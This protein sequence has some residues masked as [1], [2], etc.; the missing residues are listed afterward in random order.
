[1]LETRLKPIEI[2]KKNYTKLYNIQA[3]GVSG[4]INTGRPQICIFRDH[5]I[6]EL[7]FLTMSH[8]N[9]VGTGGYPFFKMSLAGANRNFIFESPTTIDVT[10]KTIDSINLSPGWGGSSG[11]TSKF[12]FPYVFK[13]KDSLLVEFYNSGFGVAPTIDLTLHGICR[14]DMESIK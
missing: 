12:Y 8:N 4:F 7:K 11:L 14:L 6:F 2:V 9:D 10:K 1:M 5:E 13:P 3:T